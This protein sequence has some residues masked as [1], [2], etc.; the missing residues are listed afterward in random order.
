MTFDEW[1][2]KEFHLGP[3]EPVYESSEVLRMARRAWETA[4]GQSVAYRYAMAQ[5]YKS[6][7]ERMA[8]WEEKQVSLFE[9]AMRDSGFDDEA[10][11]A[12]LV[13]LEYEGVRG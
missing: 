10:V 7:I 8:A 4:L 13:R 6:E 2:R 12:V 1:A 11:N 5:K 9:K 3:D